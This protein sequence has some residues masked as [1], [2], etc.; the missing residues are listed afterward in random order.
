M[1]NRSNLLNALTKLTQKPLTRI[2][3]DDE[4]H[5]LLHELAPH[6]TREEIYGIMDQARESGYQKLFGPPAY[7]RGAYNVVQVHRTLSDQWVIKRGRCYRQV[8]SYAYTQTPSGH[9][10]DAD[11]NTELITAYAETYWGS[12]LRWDLS[13]GYIMF[14]VIDSKRSRE[15]FLSIAQSGVI[16][17]SQDMWA[18]FEN[19]KNSREFDIDTDQPLAQQIESAA[20]IHSWDWIQCEELLG[21]VAPYNILICG[22]CAG[23][24]YEG[25]CTFCNKHYPTCATH[26]TWPAPMPLPRCMIYRA[27]GF[28][29]T[30]THPPVMAL[31]AHYAAWAADGFELPGSR[32]LDNTR[33]I[34]L[35]DDE[36]KKPTTK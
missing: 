28:D 27:S 9:E 34:T 13:Y 12:L 22:T 21:A 30:F 14:N 29:Y 10:H 26:I 33:L 24:I 19:F 11:V 7:V 18:Q 2:D 3:N 17:V 8:E 32:K 31:K 15:G 25:I 5:R 4:C 36:D 23:C 6:S 20:V 1:N 16:G 35:R